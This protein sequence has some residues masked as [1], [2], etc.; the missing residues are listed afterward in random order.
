MLLQ[1]ADRAWTDAINLDPSNSSAW[2]NRGTSR[3]QFGRWEDARSDLLRALELE[4]AQ[5][6]KPSGLL[7]N[8][9]GNADGAVGE[10]ELA[11]SHYKQAAEL[12]PEIETIALANLA[13]ALSQRG[14][15]RHTTIAAHALIV[16]CCYLP[17]RHK[18]GCC[19]LPIVDA[20][21]ANA[22]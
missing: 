20:S 11:C 10:W 19:A 13:L 22:E 5:G 15:C 17:P 1:A 4:T 7:L 9:L 14:V 6:G 18:E 12:A 21:M 8:Q 3:L 2:S 16:S